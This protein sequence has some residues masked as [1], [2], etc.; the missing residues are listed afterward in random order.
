M[1]AFTRAPP[2]DS[3]ERQAIYPD[4]TAV[5]LIGM[6][7]YR[8]ASWP[9]LQSA[10]DVHRLQRLFLDRGVAPDAITVVD[11]QPG[12]AKEL[13]SAV[14]RFGQ[15]LE[16]RH[17]AARVIVYIAAHGYTAVGMGYI[18][19]PDAPDPR[20]DP[21]GFRMAALPMST[22]LARV[23]E[24]PSRSMLLVVD[25]CFS[26]LAL[27]SLPRERFPHP[28]GSA[29]DERV[30]Q[31]ISAGTSGQS[32]S[33]DGVFAEL[34]ATGLTGAAD[35]NLDGWISGTELGM[36]LRLRTSESTGGKQTPRFGN[37]IGLGGTVE[38]E[39]WFASP[40]RLMLPACEETPKLVVSA[41]PFRDCEDCPLMRVVPGPA[42]GGAE[43]APY[44]AMGVNEVSFAEFDACFRAGGC[45]R[46]PWSRSGERG[47]LAV[48]DVSWLDAGEYTRWL[49]SV[50]G[51]LYRLPSEQEWL[52]VALPESRRL[53]RAWQERRPI[54]AN[55]DGCGGAWNGRALA[56][57][58]AFPASALGLHDLLGNVWEWMDDCRDGPGQ[59]SACRLRV[60]R[61]GAYSTRR[62]V[63][64]SL[65]S[66]EL[67]GDTRDRNIGFRV[68][69]ELQRASM[70]PRTSCAVPP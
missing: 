19:P 6:S 60:V 24:L 52:E 62:T 4:G 32:V 26:G 42:G 55:C 39:N 57:T 64:L 40:Q 44:L 47:R 16:Q 17:R 35:L 63:T 53:N 65:P 37:V 10:R 8:N 30:M 66:A 7:T 28:T 67:A 33:D 15:I 18:V 41:G 22:L 14:V 21:A 50:T 5:L 51:Y 29:G 34:M 61:G 46:W 31:V 70:L 12:S 11:P 69:R 43:R 1:C 45:R 9:A 23:A 59:A 54:D 3:V 27:E 48:T 56:P 2:P 68:A 38:G 20:K 25:A 58:G 36:Y 13:E 49:G